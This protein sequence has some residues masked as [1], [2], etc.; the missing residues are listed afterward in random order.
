ME[1]ES[2]INVKNKYFA[3]TRRALGSALEVVAHRKTPQR[4]KHL[5]CRPKRLQQKAKKATSKFSNLKKRKQQK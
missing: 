1:V 5:P 3:Y 2:A 4:A